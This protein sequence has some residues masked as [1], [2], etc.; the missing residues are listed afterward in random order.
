MAFDLEE[1]VAVLE[2]TPAALRG[3]LAGLPDAWIT[4]DEGP[5]TW[6]PYEVVGHLIHGERSNWI[7]RVRHILD[8]GESRPFTPFD[9]FAQQSESRQ[10][11]LAELLDQ[12]AGLRA[13]SLRDLAAL[14]LT[15]ADL[16]RIGAH[17]E[18]GRVTLGQLL[19][20]WTVHDLGHLAQVCRVM[21]GRTR[22]EVGPWRAYLPV[23]APRR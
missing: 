15:A 22:E 14:R 9:R 5:G 4:A 6:S 7:A 16:E 13:A 20:T 1:M 11:T 17:P 2:R 3:L 19:A 8:A 23:L 12:F 18:F 10:R 21:A